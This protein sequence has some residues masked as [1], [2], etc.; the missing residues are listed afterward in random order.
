MHALGGIQSRKLFFLAATMT[1][2]MVDAVLAAGG[3]DLFT[4][5][6]IRNTADPGRSYELA[7][8]TCEP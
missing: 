3:D 6:G 1:V 7:A 8:W 2:V 5:C 4:E